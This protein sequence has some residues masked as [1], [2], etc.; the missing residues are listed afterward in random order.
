MRESVMIGLSKKIKEKLD[1]I[2]NRK[3]VIF[4]NHKSG[5]LFDFEIANQG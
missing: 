3:K 1:K 2:A 4:F 5:N